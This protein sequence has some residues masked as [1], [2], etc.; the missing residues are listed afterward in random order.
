MFILWDG[1]GRLPPSFK[2]NVEERN[3]HFHPL[4]QYIV[5]TDIQDLPEEQ[6]KWK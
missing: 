4:F 5:V 3:S 2:K 1:S 6:D